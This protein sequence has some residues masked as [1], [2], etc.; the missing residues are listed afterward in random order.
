[1]RLVSLTN[2]RHRGQPIERDNQL[3]EHITPQDCAFGGLNANRM[4]VAEVG[5]ADA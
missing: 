1:L 4:N 3:I 2:F 5:R